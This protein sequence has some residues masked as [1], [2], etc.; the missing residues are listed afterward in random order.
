M[1]QFWE[2]VSWVAGEA[3]GKNESSLLHSGDSSESSKNETALKKLVD[4]IV[5]S[6]WEEES[7]AKGSKEKNASKEGACEEEPK[8]KTRYDS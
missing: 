4:G 3:S 2:G 8:E 1:K 5:E 6:N 7:H